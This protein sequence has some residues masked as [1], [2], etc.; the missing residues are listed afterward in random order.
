MYADTYI[1][2]RKGVVGD[3]RSLCCVY[4]QYRAFRADNNSVTHAIQGA[5]MAPFF[6]PDIEK[7]DEHF[8][9]LSFSSR[10]FIM[11]LGPY[12][13]TPSLSLSGEED[14]EQANRK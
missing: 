11:S 7:K 2:T 12:T 8:A 3:F 4:S 14:S 1:H 6:P 9:V 5:R 10:K 13:H